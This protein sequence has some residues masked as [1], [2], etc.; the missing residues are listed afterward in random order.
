MAASNK[1]TPTEAGG[2]AI[3]EFMADGTGA[4]HWVLDPA[5]SQVEFHSTSM[6]KTAKIH[7]RFAAL[8]GEGTVSPDGTVVGELTIETASLDTGIKK[9]DT[10]LRTD[11]FFAVTEHPTATYAVARISPLEANQVQVHGTLTIRGHSELLPFTAT[12]TEATAD[13]VTI[14]AELTVDRSRFGMTWSPLKMAS[15]NNRVV[16]TARFQRAGR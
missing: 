9:R 8:S 5:A 15:M 16:I 3:A 11:H 14:Q 12:V 1:S 10:H 6:W 4:G 13:A 7:G 2:T